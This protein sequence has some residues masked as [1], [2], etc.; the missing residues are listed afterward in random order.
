MK[1]ESTKKSSK[2]SMEPKGTG[3][4][5]HGDS[6]GHASAGSHSHDNSGRKLRSIN[7][8]G[9]GSHHTNHE[10]NGGMHSASQMNDW[11]EE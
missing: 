10:F 5:W 4:G 7:V 8:Q 11:D 2:L 6:K 1:R 9:H 3:R